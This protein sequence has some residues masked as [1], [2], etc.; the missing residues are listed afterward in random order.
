MSKFFCFDCLAKWCSRK[1]TCPLC[2]IELFLQDIKII[3]T[4]NTKKEN[5][6]H[7]KIEIFEY[8]KKYVSIYNKS[9]IL[10]LF[11]DKKD[12]NIIHT[13]LYENNF[14]N[15]SINNRNLFKKNNY[16]I[17]LLNFYELSKINY[18]NFTQIFKIN[19]SN[20]ILFD[21]SFILNDSNKNIKIHNLFF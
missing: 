16:Q 12:L 17:T 8:I 6:N 21:Y 2:R 15:I 1:N 19:V 20:K 3:N 18:F 7:F 5:A 9:N 14:K 11:S 10:F 4:N 13:F